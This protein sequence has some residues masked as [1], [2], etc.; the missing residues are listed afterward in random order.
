MCRIRH[1]R[2]EGEKMAAE[3]SIYRKV[4]VI[5]EGGHVSQKAVKPGNK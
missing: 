2:D 5:N 3:G 4:D 1:P